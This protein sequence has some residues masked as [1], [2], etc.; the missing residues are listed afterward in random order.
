MYARRYTYVIGPE[1]TI[2][3]AI[4]TICGDLATSV[5]QGRKCIAALGEVDPVSEDLAIAVVGGLEKHHWMLNSQKQ[6]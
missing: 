6:L 5:Q 1:G 3:Q 4:D 2:E